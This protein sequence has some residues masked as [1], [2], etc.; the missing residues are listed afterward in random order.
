MTPAAFARDVAARA[1]RIAEALAYGETDFA[2]DA[3]SDL[4]HDAVAIAEILERD[5]EEAA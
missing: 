5:L 4:E 1:A 3:A 2:I